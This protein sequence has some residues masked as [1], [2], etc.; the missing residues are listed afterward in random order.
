[1]QGTTL[2]TPCPVIVK[3]LPCVVFERQAADP[4]EGTPYYAPYVMLLVLFL[5]VFLQLAGVSGS[6]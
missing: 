4:V 5:N 1:M 2:E 3:T 6:V